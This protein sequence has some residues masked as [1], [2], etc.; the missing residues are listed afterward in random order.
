MFQYVIRRLFLNILPATTWALVDLS[1][2]LRVSSTIAHFRAYRTSSFLPLFNQKQDLEPRDR[3]A[4]SRSEH[5][6]I[7]ERPRSGG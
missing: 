7:E 2:T 3:R 1:P 5:F 4:R 6:G